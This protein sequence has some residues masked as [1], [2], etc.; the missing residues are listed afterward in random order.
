MPDL[1]KLDRQILTSMQADCRVSSE[2]IAQSI[3]LS[4]TALI[5]KQLAVASR[6]ILIDRPLRGSS[7]FITCDTD[8]FGGDE[9]SQGVPILHAGTQRPTSIIHYKNNSFSSLFYGG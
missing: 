6:D 8:R 1:D 7:A 5:D 3:G 9:R 2:S 4:A